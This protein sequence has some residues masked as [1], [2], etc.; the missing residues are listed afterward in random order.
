[1][2]WEAAKTWSTSE[3]VENWIAKPGC[4]VAGC[5][6]PVVCY[7]IASGLPQV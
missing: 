5:F 4:A 7:V 2:T 3:I 1:M 6:S